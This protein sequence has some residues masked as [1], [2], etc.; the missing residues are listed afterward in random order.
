[1]AEIFGVSLSA[2]SRALGT[3]LV[4]TLAISTIIWAALATK[5][6]KRP[7]YITATVLMMVGCIIAGEC[8]RYSVLLGSRIIQGAGQAPLEFLVGSSIADLYPTHQRGIPVALWTIA[9]LNGINVTPPIS[10]QVFAHLGWRWCWRIFWIACITL[11]VVQIFCM[12]ETTYER[13]ALV[14]RVRSGEYD[15]S[16]AEKGDVLHLENSV[17]AKHSYIHSLKVYNGLFAPQHSFWRLLV[18]PLQ[19]IV[20]PIVLYGGVTYG[21]YITYL[22]VIATGAAQVFAGQYGFGPVGTGNVYIAALVADFIA[23][24]MIGPLT[25]FSASFFSRRNKGIFEPEFRLPIGMIA[26]ALFGGFGLIGFGISAQRQDNVWGPIMSFA[27]LNFGITVGCSAIISYIV[28]SHRHSSEAALGG[29]IFLKNALSAGFSAFT[30]IW[31]AQGIQDA[32]VTMG[33]TCIA[34]CLLTIPMWIYGKRVRSWLSRRLKVEKEE[35]TLV[36]S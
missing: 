12:P 2:I 30:N 14:T 10:G 29:V 32:F 33:G 15:D 21:L 4:T 19:M 7:I 28:E 24:A 35:K 16:A 25:D 23:A 8:D 17:P 20:S 1:M 34:T 22:V 36:A 27:L 3:T 11:L 18:E 13:A 26:M 6:G 5:L 9:L 31:I